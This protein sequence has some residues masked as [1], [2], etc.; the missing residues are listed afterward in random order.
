VQNVK[1]L[2]KFVQEY[3]AEVRAKAAAK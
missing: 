2:A 1:D 3:S